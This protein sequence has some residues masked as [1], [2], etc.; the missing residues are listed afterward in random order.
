MKRK[1]MMRKVGMLKKSIEKTIQKR[2]RVVI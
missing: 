2:G 1:M